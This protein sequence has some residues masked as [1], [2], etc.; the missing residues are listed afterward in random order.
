MPAFSY[1]SFAVSICVV[2]EA[3]LNLALLPTSGVLH[4]HPDVVNGRTSCRSSKIAQ[5]HEHKGKSGSTVQLS[6]AETA[7]QRLERQRCQ[8][9]LAC[10]IEKAHFSATPSWYWTSCH[11]S[12]RTCSCPLHSLGYQ[13]V[14]EP[15]GGFAKLAQDSIELLLG[16]IFTET[17]CAIQNLWPGRT[18]DFSGLFKDPGRA[19]L[20]RSFGYALGLAPP[21]EA[22]QKHV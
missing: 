3:V 20:F 12:K 14:S 4:Q 10:I 17:T 11:A 15:G 22:A 13:K 6:P 9:T 21:V 8:N 16:V 18:W 19:R 1:S 2:S 7:P 5:Q